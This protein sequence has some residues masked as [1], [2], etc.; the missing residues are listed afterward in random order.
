[1]RIFGPGARFRVFWNCSERT[2]PAVTGNALGVVGRCIMRE[3]TIPSGILSAMRVVAES[4]PHPAIM[5]DGPYLVAT[6]RQVC[7]I[8]R[9]DMSDDGPVLLP[10][11]CPEHITVMDGVVVSD[12]GFV[13][14]PA[15]VEFPDWRTLY[16]KRIGPPAQ[17]TTAFADELIRRVTQVGELLGDTRPS[18][19]LAQDWPS[20]VSWP[21]QNVQMVLATCKTLPALDRWHV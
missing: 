12:T 1:M 20:A 4:G 15:G 11:D 16:R 17:Y 14:G 18:W 9:M 10:P 7:L 8:H 5:L 13:S 2:S 3:L 6:D 19:Y 21:M